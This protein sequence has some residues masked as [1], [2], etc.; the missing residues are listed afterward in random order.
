ME[1]LEGRTLAERLDD[2]PLPLVEALKYSVEIC[3]A[4]AEAHSH[5]VI[6]RDVKPGNVMVTREGVKLLDFGLA[7]IRQA[8]ADDS[9]QETMETM[10][11]TQEGGILGTVSYM[12]P[13][14][15]EGRRV[16]ARTDL[17]AARRSAVRDGHRTPAVR[18][19][20]QGQRDCRDPD[21]GSAG[22]GDGSAGHTPRVGAC[23]QEMPG[24]ES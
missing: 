9:A 11:L 24:Q 4:L 18:R 16:D 22:Y 1:H 19:G 7:K 15:L 13:E 20:E 23:R 17:F 21:Y 14:Q 6:H 3:A 8:E 5:G 12:S 2:G 10:H